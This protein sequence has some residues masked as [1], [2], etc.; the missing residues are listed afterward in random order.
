MK[1]ERYLY[2][3]LKVFLQ[4]FE[5][6]KWWRSLVKGLK[7]SSWL[8]ISMLKSQRVKPD[9]LNAHLPY[10]I[11]WNPSLISLRLTLLLNPLQL[12]EKKLKEYYEVLKIYYANKDITAWL[13]VMSLPVHYVNYFIISCWHI[14]NIKLLKRQ[15]RLCQ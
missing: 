13:W 7:K 8:L 5:F 1:L 2:I 12:F 14:V 15:C 4:L 6:V 10:N 3:Y 11:T 9:C